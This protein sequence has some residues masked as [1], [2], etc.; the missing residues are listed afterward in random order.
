MLVQAA[1]V[2]GDINASSKMGEEQARHLELYLKECFQYVFGALPDAGVSSFTGFRG[3]AWQFVVKQPVW[4]IRCAI[5]FRAQ[6][7]VRSDRMFGKKIHTAA[8]I[9]FGTI[10]FLPDE[11]SKAGGGEAYVVSGKR[12]DKLRRRIPGMGVAGL[13]RYNGCLDSLLGVIDALIRHWTPLQAQAV[14]YA[15]QDYSQET[16]ATKWESSVSQQAINKHLNAAGW[17]AIKPALQWIETTLEG[18]IN[19]NNQINN[20]S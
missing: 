19:E 12:L 18:C 9:G 17:P 16:I 4:A 7:L 15:L 3:D 20:R 11:I 5:L 6:L 2:T 8:A 10:T 14:Q 13:E 1:V